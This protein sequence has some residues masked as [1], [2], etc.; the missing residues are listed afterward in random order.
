MLRRD[1]FHSYFI[2]IKTLRLPGKEPFLL[3]LVVPHDIFILPPK[4]LR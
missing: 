3:F 4:V 1:E 2:I